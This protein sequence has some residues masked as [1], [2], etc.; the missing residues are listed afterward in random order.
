MQKALFNQQVAQYKA[1]IASFD[2][3]INQ[4]QATIQKFEGD[5]A[6][7]QQ[8]EEIAKQIET[9]GPP[10]RSTAL[11]QSSICGIAG[12]TLRNVAHARDA[13]HNSLIEA[14]HTLASS[15]ADREAFIQQWSTQLSQDLV[16]ARTLL[17]LP[18]PTGKGGEASGS[19][20]VDGCGSFDRSDRGEALGRLGIEGRRYAFHA[21]ASQDAGGGG[22]SGRFS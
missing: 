15:K 2:A 20:A 11:A 6:R 17:I 5:E 14:Q 21:D 22:N 19:G 12:C 1:Q 13:T 9:C 4:T 18:K 3:K 8:R 10:S 7:Y 16:T